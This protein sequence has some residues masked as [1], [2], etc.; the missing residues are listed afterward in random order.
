MRISG[1]ACRECAC[2]GVLIP[3]SAHSQA[4]QRT[5]RPLL[6]TASVPLTT[7]KDSSSVPAAGAQ[8]SDNDDD[9]NDDVAVIAMRRQRVNLFCQRF[10]LR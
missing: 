4:S 5:L 9:G 3:T 1:Y 10:K 7:K 8:S 6:R 2:K